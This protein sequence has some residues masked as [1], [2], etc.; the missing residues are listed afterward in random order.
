MTTKLFCAVAAAPKVTV[1]VVPEIAIESTKASTFPEGRKPIMIEPEVAVPVPEVC[2]T[3]TFTVTNS[4]FNSISPTISSLSIA[5]VI[6]F[7]SMV[8]LEE[9][10]DGGTSEPLM[11]ALPMPSFLVIKNRSVCNSR[12]SASNSRFVMNCSAI[13]FWF[14]LCKPSVGISFLVAI[15]A[16]RPSV[17]NRKAEFG[18]VGKRLNMVC[19]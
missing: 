2:P 1:T 7:A 3:S 6:V 19:V 10:L 18:V 5:C 8:M 9:I 13:D 4:Y 14:F 17:I 16:K 12:F 11:S 15:F